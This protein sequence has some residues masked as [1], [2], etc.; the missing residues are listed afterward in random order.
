VLADPDDLSKDGLLALRS[1]DTEVRPDVQ[2]S[3]A[4]LEAPNSQTT[5]ADLYEVP[6]PNATPQMLTPPDRKSAAE[7]REANPG[8]GD[9]A[10]GGPAVPTQTEERQDDEQIA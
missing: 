5:A 6:E 3:T 9:P 8:C 1:R 4:T 10:T 2:L 7:K